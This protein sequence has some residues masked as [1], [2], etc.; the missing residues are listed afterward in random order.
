MNQDSPNINLLPRDLQS[1]KKKN[2]KP[3]QAVESSYTDPLPKKFVAASDS[4]QPKAGLSSEKKQGL[5]SRFSNL[6][7]RKKNKS[8]QHA[9]GAGPEKHNSPKILTAIAQKKEP[10]DLPSAKPLP[11]A[12]FVSAN[13]KK[14]PEP[15]SEQKKTPVSAHVSNGVEARTV[16]TMH[17]PNF[18]ELQR[19]SIL[20]EIAKDEPEPKKQ[21]LSFWRRLFRRKKKLTPEQEKL[22]KKQEQPKPVLEPK[23]ITEQKKDPI[24]P[25]SKESMPTLVQNKSVSQPQPQHPAPPKPTLQKM[26]V[27]EE[28]KEKNSNQAVTDAPIHRQ[29]QFDVNLLTPEYEQVFNVG[30]P[31]ITLLAWVIAT[32]SILGLIYGGILMYKTRAQSNLD[33]LI[34]VNKALTQTIGTYGTLQGEDEILLNKAGAVQQLLRQHISWSDF[35]TQLE[36]VTTPEVTYLS[37]AVSTEGTMVISAIST[38]YTS[39]ARQMKVYEATPWIAEL[40]ITS[41][42]LVEASARLPEGVAFDIE[43]KIDANEFIIS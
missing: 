18:L 3:S 11:S 21:T 5:F 2:Q 30:N 23:K 29:Q 37:I 22:P 42:S 31:K 28:T 34:A 36:S 38:N 17:S 20:R 16:Q 40:T 13:S 32:I 9:T 10:H 6:F 43:L 8:E 14:I 19:Q 15:H 39:L 25:P 7:K 35:L 24:V 1:N 26:V 27:P 12:L 4:N 33:E 41:A